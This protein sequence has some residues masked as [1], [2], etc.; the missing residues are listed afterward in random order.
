MPDWR[1]LRVLYEL[2]DSHAFVY[3][4]R[5]GRYAQRSR[6]HSPHSQTKKHPKVF[7]Y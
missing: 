4:H 2:A 1:D 6:P 5:V 7:F 3:W